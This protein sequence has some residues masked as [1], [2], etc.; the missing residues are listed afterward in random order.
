MG[1][2]YHLKHF[3]TQSVRNGRKDVLFGLT[4]T[5]FF[6]DGCHPASKFTRKDSIW[7]SGRLSNER[8]LVYSAFWDH[9]ILF[10]CL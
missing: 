2:R 4:K 8:H 9:F 3:F 1:T 7:R 5:F 10:F 6:S